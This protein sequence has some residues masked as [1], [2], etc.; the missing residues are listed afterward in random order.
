MKDLKP[1]YLD[2]QAT[3]PLDPR[4]LDAMLPYLTDQFGNA[5][6]SSHG[7][8][9]HAAKA[10][11]TAR[12]RIAAN[13]GGSPLGLVF[14]SGATESINL[15]LK[16]IASH[17]GSE[18]KN[19]I[20][21]CQTEHP[22]VMDTCQWLETQGFQLTYMP[23][24]KDGRLDLGELE[25]AITEQTL[26]LSIMFANNESGVIHD[27]AAIGALAKT[28]GVF[29]HC[30]GVQ[31]VGKVPLNVETLGIDLLS[32]SAHK[33]YGPKGMGALWVRRKQPRV[34]M[35]LQMH[36]GGHERGFRSGTLNVP[37]IVGLDCALDLCIQHQSEAQAHLFQCRQHFLDALQAQQIAYEING[38]M[39]H[40]LAGN[41]NLR[42]PNISAAKLM[43]AVPSLAL[44]RG[45]A[46]T[47]AVPSPSRV[48]MAMG[49]SAKQ[50]GESLRISFGRMTT[51]AEVEKAAKIIIQA[52]QTMPL[53]AD[54][55]PA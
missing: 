39:T 17:Y 24:Q 2:Y 30:D 41:L 23:V 11:N 14:T 18:P 40:R 47:S 16:G 31:A 29:F 44:A 49:L 27:I 5:A 51:L 35:G 19:H 21:T 48:L 6:S 33:I 53:S 32:F 28:R 55:N 34:R 38:N 26:A 50:A 42:F 54:E 1:I 9:Q 46:C 22:A 36:G 4:V 45:S 13:I 43:Q 37:G 10:V 8:G 25:Q 20:I 7:F 15:A 52:I 3:T 12:E